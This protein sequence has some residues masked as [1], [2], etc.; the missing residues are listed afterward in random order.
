MQI[1]IE[2]LVA[3]SREISGF[4]KAFVSETD[5]DF[6]RVWRSKTYIQV[7]QDLDWLCGQQA[8]STCMH[9]CI[10]RCVAVARRP[11]QRFLSVPPDM[12]LEQAMLTS[13]TGAAANSSGNVVM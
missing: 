3:A 2:R 1:P 12:G 9:S 5:P 10:E 7:R 11:L 13:A 4:L 6:G 8:R